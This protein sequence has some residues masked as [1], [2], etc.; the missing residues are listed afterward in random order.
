M[1]ML[2]ESLAITDGFGVYQGTGCGMMQLL[3]LIEKRHYVSRIV[4][5]LAGEVVAELFFLL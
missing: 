3:L 2:R 5:F 4:S 1:M